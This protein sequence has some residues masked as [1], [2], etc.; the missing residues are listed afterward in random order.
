MNIITGSSGGLGKSLYKLFIDNDL[1][2]IGIDKVNSKTCD[3]IFDFSKN[4]LSELFKKLNHFR[5]D[6]VTF[7][8]AIGNSK[9]EIEKY[10]LEE[11]IRI[12][13]TSNLDL[14]NFFKPNC[15]ENS[16]IIFISSVHSNAT[17]NQSNK[18]ALSKNF[19]EGIYRMLSLENI[20]FNISLIRLGATKTKMLKKNVSNLKILKEKIPSKT[21]LLPD[22]VTSFIFDIH[23]KHADLLNKS[24]LQVDGGILL[25]LASD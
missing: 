4:N 13:S 19:L 5:I 17:N 15:D 22:Q 8:H 11:Y 10:T 24:I 7:C 2:V 20:N 9:E 1:P 18:Y 3:L 16:S 25:K 12:N 6:S 23:T 21:I 14:F